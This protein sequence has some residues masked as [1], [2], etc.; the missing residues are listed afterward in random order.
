MYSVQLPLADDDVGH[1]VDDGR[2]LVLRRRQF[3]GMLP[4]GA[5]ASLDERQHDAVGARRKIEHRAVV[6]L[7][8]LPELRIVE[9][10]RAAR[11]R[12]ELSRIVVE[13][14]ERVV[15]QQDL[16]NAALVRGVHEPV[17]ERLPLRI[18]NLA[19]IHARSRATARDG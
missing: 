7:E 14:V 5:R 10:D 2:E 4:L 15:P 1:R 16:R 8:P 3:R 9:I 18:A 11:A 12:A 13:V 19:Q 6:G 17:D